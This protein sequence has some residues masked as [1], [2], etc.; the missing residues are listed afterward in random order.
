MRATVR[1]RLLAGLALWPLLGRAAGLDDTLA[2][3]QQ[4]WRP[5]LAWRPDAGWRREAL[6]RARR[7]ILL[8]GDDGSGFATEVLAEEDRGSHTALSLTLRGALGDR[9]PALYLRP[10]GAGPHPAIV[11]LHDHGARFDIGKEK[12]IRPLQPS[13]SAEAWVQRYFGGQFVGDTLAEAGF[14]VLAI[15]ALGWGERSRP[16]LARDDQQALANHLMQLGH[17]WAG[18]IASDDLRSHRWLRERPDVDA[19]RVAVLGFSMGA[20]RAW[21]L[22]A[23]CDEVS[24]CVAAHWMCT[25]EGLLRPGEHTLVGQSAFSMV[26]PGLAAELDHPDVAALIAPRPLL[27]FGSPDDRLFPWEAVQAAWTNL[28]RAWAPRRAAFS[29]LATEG[30]HRFDAP[31]Q[32][33]ALAWLQRQGR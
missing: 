28:A 21:Q 2:R 20:L 17:S 13:P 29:T 3:A 9:V 33:A 22:A 14:A 26:H 19:K 24:A 16:G 5:R 11:L 12:L 25:R 23:V 18:L 8:P 32:A 27:L 31:Q 1:R 7:H 10:R 4:A 15:D 30:G 6:D